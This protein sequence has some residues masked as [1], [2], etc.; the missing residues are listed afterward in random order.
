MDHV[1]VEIEP[2]TEDTY[3]GTSIARSTKFI[4]VPI[5]IEA[6]L[7][8]LSVRL[9]FEV[10]RV[11]PLSVH[12]LSKHSKTLNFPRTNFIYARNIR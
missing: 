1:R 5:P 8:S 9:L 7:R 11:Q 6:K 3:A 2:D 10:C 12:D 4:A